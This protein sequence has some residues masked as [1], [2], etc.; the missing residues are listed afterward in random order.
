MGGEK[1]VEEPQ[2]GWCKGSLKGKSG[3]YGRNI[4]GGQIKPG[5]L[6]SEV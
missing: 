5:R 2:V 3:R 6:G 1:P 4:D